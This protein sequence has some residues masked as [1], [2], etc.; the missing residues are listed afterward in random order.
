MPGLAQ[1]VRY[2]LRSLRRN[3]GFAAVA[4]LTLALGIGANTAVFSVLNA[5][6]LRP[7]PFQS[8]EPLMLLWTESPRQ[9]LREGRSAY[10]DVEQW[11]AQSRSFADMAV[12]D[13]VRLTLTSESGSEQITVARVSPNF[14]GLLG[15]QP[16]RGRTFSEQEAGERQRVAVISY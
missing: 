13:P 4:V 6:I 9:A 11:R 16:S 3:P 14:F 8:P 12:L 5:V 2:A 1:D 15:V 10:G 7:L